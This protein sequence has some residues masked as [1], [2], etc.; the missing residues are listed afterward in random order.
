MSDRSYSRMKRVCRGCVF[1]DGESCLNEE[2]PDDYWAGLVTGTRD[3]C[4]FK[5]AV[6]RR[7]RA[8]QQVE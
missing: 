8:K 3:A 6:I 7:R 4:D 5:V 2:M 1:W